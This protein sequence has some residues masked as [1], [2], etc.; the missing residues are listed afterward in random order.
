M[1]ARPGVSIQYTLDTI[2]ILLLIGPSSWTSTRA[3]CCSPP[4]AHSSGV[5]PHTG[6]VAGSSAGILGSTLE[7][8]ISRRRGQV[9]SSLTSHHTLRVMIL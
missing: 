4:A 5:H 9:A 7:P 8:I 6:G 1:W 3:S 2:S